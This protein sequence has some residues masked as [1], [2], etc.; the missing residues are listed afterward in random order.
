MTAI[1]G[2]GSILLS[3]GMYDHPCCGP[4]TLIDT[5][6]LAE[7]AGFDGVVV[8]EHV[9]MGERTDRYPWGPFPGRSDQP[10]LDPLVTL[11]AIGA[12]TS[13]LRLCTG[14]LIAPLR[15]AVLLAKAAATIDRMTGGRLELGVGTGWQREEFDASGIDFD[16]RGRLL[17]DTIAA[18]RALWRGDVTSFASTTVS[19]DRIWCEPTPAS[20][21]GPP[22]LFSGTLTPRNIR[23]IVDL[24][25]GWIPIMGES[26][27]GIVAGV[28]LLRAGFRDAERDIRSLRVR[29]PLP[30]VRNGA[31]QPVLDAMLEAA[32]ALFDAG[33]TDAV[34]PLAAF[35]RTV[36]ERDAWF[37]SAKTVLAASR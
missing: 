23:R 36:E 28:D 13:R 29:V 12:V 11:P 33:V 25:D 7:A 30:V 15:P 14:V 19:F 35:V 17:S 32:P 9:V 8:S 26:I 18:C 34:I 4:T 5:A 1:N 3:F 21:N 37:T 22:V 20:P 27:E 31:G 2:T 24:G 16:A 6:R 10:W